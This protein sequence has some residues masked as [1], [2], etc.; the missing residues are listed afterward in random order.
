MTW[1]YIFSEN[2]VS[3]LECYILCRIY[4]LFFEKRLSGW[5]HLGA[6]VLGGLALTL[7]LYWLNA[8]ALF[9][10][11]NTAA[12]IAASSLIALLLYRANFIQTL[13][14]S[15][16]YYVLILAYDFLIVSIVELL[17]EVD[18]FTLTIITEVGPARTAYIWFQKFSLIAVCLI[19]R[20]HNRGRR[21]QINNKVSLALIASGMF[22]FFFM[23]FLINAVLMGDAAEIKKSVLIAWLFILLFF[24]GV[25][26]LVAAY[27][28]MKIQRIEKD[29]VAFKADALEDNSMRLNL[30]YSEI[31]KV[32][33]DFHNHLRVMRVMAEAGQYAELGKYLQMLADGQPTVQMRRYTGNEVVDA[34]LNNKADK[35][36]EMHVPLS[37]D[38]AYPEDVKIRTV[39]ICALLVNLLDGALEA[40]AEV[41]DSKKRFAEVSITSA[42]AMLIIRVK[43]AAAHAAP[44]Q[45]AK[46]IDT[47]REA[48][49]I[50]G[51]DAQM[52]RLIVDRYQGRVEQTGDDFCPETRILLK[53]VVN[54]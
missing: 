51:Y 28:N 53:N 12:V 32:S 46:W 26:M 54:L 21:I 38:A 35:A 49:R 30:A 14:V 24:A 17:Y 43:S 33:H 34:V 8:L 13:S 45:D 5:R 50:H 25:L 41:P 1:F 27:S 48:K 37:I 39:D 7:M 36:R 2:M 40:A 15:V 52:I 29:V 16:I 18:N 3:F 19:A 4:C 31:A 20:R 44:P 47:A 22:P 6:C 9:S 42:D 11:L 10:F 23:Q